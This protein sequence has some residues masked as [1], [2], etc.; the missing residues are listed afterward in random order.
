MAVSAYGLLTA[1]TSLSWKASGG[2]YAITLTSLANAAAR[3]GAKGDLGEYWRR[4]WSVLLAAS[5]AVAPTAGNQLEL[6]WAGSPSATAGTDNPGGASGTDASFGTPGEYKF[7]LHRIGFLYLSNNAGTGVQRQT[8]DFFPRF[9]YGMPVLVNSSG[10][11][12]GST[13]GD[14]EIRLTP[15]DDVLATTNGG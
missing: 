9:R 4:R 12:L 8:F 15:L 13:A 2:D 10:Q 3:Q 1:G 6:W 11:A 7:Q 14:H 5:C